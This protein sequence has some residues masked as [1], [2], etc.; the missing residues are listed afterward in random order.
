MGFL[1]LRT[2][3]IEPGVCNL[4]AM[5]LISKPTG[6]GFEPD[7]EETFGACLGFPIYDGARFVADIE[8]FSSRYLAFAT[9]YSLRSRLSVALSSYIFFSISLFCSAES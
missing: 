7:C 2:A 1:T 5:S 6:T 4:A 9:F 3:I 8:D